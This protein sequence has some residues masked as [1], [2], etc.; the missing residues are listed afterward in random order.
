MKGVAVV[1]VIR[2][3]REYQRRRRDENRNS[4]PRLL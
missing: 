3:E 2:E 4:R 1:Q